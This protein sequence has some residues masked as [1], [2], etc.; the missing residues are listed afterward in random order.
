MG[1]II[2]SNGGTVIVDDDMVDFL[3]QWTWS[4][5]NGYARRRA[6]P[7]D[8]HYS[9]RIH[10]SHVIAG[11]TKEQRLANFVVDHKNFNRLDNRKRNLRIVPHRYNCGHQSEESKSKLRQNQKLATRAAALKPRTELQ[12]KLARERAKKINSSGKNRHVG[13]DNYQSK[14]VV[15]VESGIVF[16]SVTE[17]AQAKGRVYS[18]VRSWLNGYNPNPSTLRN[19][20]DV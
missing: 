15:C 3:N 19:L 2:L 13:A 8:N 4:N 11:L 6:A 17:A 12:T 5:E 14:K 9:Q 10:M 20:S 7:E 16:D 1:Q 18:T